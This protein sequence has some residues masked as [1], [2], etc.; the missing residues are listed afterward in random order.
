MFAVLVIGGALFGDEFELQ[1]HETLLTMVGDSP[2]VL[3]VVAVIFAVVLA[4][5]FE[6]I[7]FRGM[8]QTMVRSATGQPWVAVV[9]TSV[10]FVMM[11]A[12]KTH[13][14]ALFGLSVGMGYAYEKSGSLYRSIFIHIMFNGISVAGTLLAGA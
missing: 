7:L 11:H 9:L 10:I 8:F 13:W 14:L 1:K 6:E 12:S 5:V 2:M 3:R 4:P